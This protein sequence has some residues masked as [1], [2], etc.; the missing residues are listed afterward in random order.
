M[1]L[2]YTLAGSLVVSLYIG[3]HGVHLLVKLPIQIRGAFGCMLLVPS[4]HL[5]GINSRP[6]SIGAHGVDSFG[7]VFILV[8]SLLYHIVQRRWWLMSRCVPQWIFAIHYPLVS[9]TLVLNPPI[10]NTHVLDSTLALLGPHYLMRWNW[11]VLHNPPSHP[12]YPTHSATWLN[13]PTSPPVL[14]VSPVLPP[15]SH[16]P[17]RHH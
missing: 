16:L 4:L 14:T 9:I 6:G 5:S 2:S 8:D 15:I 7:E 10:L 13:L 17:Y 11:P 12:F 1:Y 3:A